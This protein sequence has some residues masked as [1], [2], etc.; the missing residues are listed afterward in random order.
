MRQNT[1]VEQL[2]LLD[3]RQ[4]STRLRT[5]PDN[6]GGVFMEQARQRL[7]L[8]SFAFI[9]CCLAVSW[10]L[11]EAMTMRPDV[12]TGLRRAAI[13]S[14][15]QGMR[16]DITDRNGELLATSLMA[17]S[18]YADSRLVLDPE[19]T[20]SRLVKALPGL[21]RKEVLAK[22]KSGK[23]FVWI[24]RHLTPREHAAVH[25]LGLPGISFQ[26]EERRIW[27]AG[28]LAAHAVGFTGVD[29]SGLM[30]I[31][32]SF[33]QTLRTS[34]TPLQLS[35]DMR[36]QHILKREL[37]ASMDEFHSTGGSG[38]VM[39]A[40]NGEILAMVSLPDFDPN[41]PA[42][43]TDS[44]MFNRA[45]LGVYEM[46]ST[47]KIFNT[48]LALES[49]LAD[50]SDTFDATRPIR[51]GK[52]SISDFHP[53]NRWLTT[54]EIFRYSSNI[55]SVRMV[56]KVG[57]TRQKEF[58]ERLGLTRKS[59]IELPETGIPQLPRP[60]N[61]V[62]AMTISFG[63]GMAVSSLNMVSAT[64]SVIN[65]GTLVTP[66]LVRR[67]QL[68]EGRRVI[69][70]ETSDQ[71]RRLMRL[72]VTEG[73]A[74]KADARGYLVGGK[75]GTAEKSGA[76]GY[77]KSSLLSSFI[78]AFPAHDPQYIVFVMLDEPRGNARSYGL[79]TAGWTAAPLAGRIIAQMGP[80]TGMK[81]YDSNS[82]EIRQ[83]LKLDMPTGGKALASFSPDDG[84]GVGVGE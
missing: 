44:A 26:Q 12:E 13:V 60:W 43:I 53:E 58:L 68:F 66:T 40:R 36:I 83:A 35:L 29:G 41:A 14:T 17:A 76:G 6:S 18:A 33:D 51:V 65:G 20:A 22:L 79:A 38:V 70:P 19:E 62:S 47:F 24:R 46:G 3:I 23:H 74:M 4:P 2:S 56:Q 57:T 7:R 55:G 63:H 84:G 10:R 48:A 54:A 11:A 49:G 50:L 77:E 67:T 9:F 81:P 64:A 37:K 28:P 25:R 42:G 34:A 39:D 45:T 59:G 72:V 1:P 52:Y 61:D 31:E 5:E 71:M 82:P 21:N 15:A 16:A 80:L 78:G 32:R 69:S 73:T 8:A 27:P 30:G 75:T